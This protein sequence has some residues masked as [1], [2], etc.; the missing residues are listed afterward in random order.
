MAARTKL[1]R[2]K[3]KGN[4]GKQQQSG[5]AVKWKIQMIIVME[6]RKSLVSSA[7]QGGQ[8]KGL[9]AGEKNQ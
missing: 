3:K 1:P 4:K 6:Q 2:D 8:K 7:S 9:R 5:Q